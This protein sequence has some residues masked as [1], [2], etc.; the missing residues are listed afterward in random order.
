MSGRVCEL[1]LKSAL[2][3]NV[4]QIT[5]GGAFPH[6]S[7][8]MS[9]FFNLPGDYVLKL[10]AAS[11]PGIASLLGVARPE[12]SIVVT[13]LLSAL[14]WVLACVVLWGSVILVKNLHRITDA[15]VRTAWYQVVQAGGNARTWAICRFTHLIPKRRCDDQHEAMPETQFDDFDFTVL[16]ATADCGSAFTTS[17]PEL[18]STYGLRPAQFQ[19][20]L[21]KLHSSKMIIAVIGCTDGFDNY[22]LT[23]YGAAYI[24]MWDRP[25]AS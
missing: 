9:N 10:L 19:N 18:A 22:R 14:A 6:H 25:R 11:A 8:C 1:L 4:I 7:S 15:I 16:Q 12:E 5:A 23:D 24:K 13:I 2:Y 17:A 20:S 3:Q 21:S